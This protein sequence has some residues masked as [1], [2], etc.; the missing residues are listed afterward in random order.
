[1]HKVEWEK[2]TPQR[3]SKKYGIWCQ[4]IGCD[5]CK[6]CVQKL[7][8]TKTQKAKDKQ[9][10]NKRSVRKKKPDDRSLQDIISYKVPAFLKNR[11]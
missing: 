7:I 4:S 5:L 1:M 3:R 10:K 2:N 9:D 11:K 6:K 8:T